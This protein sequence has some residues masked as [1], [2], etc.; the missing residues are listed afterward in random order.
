M[1]MRKDPT[2][3][4]SIRILLM[5]TMLGG[6]AWCAVPAHAGFGDMVK[7]AKQAVKGE[8]PKAPNAAE[9]GPIKSRMTPE[10]TAERLTQFQ[11]GMEAEVAEREKGRKFLAT[12]KSKE[13]YNACQQKVAASPEAQKVMMMVGDV[14]ENATM[15]DM[16][17]VTEKMNTQIAA[18]LRK[19]CGEDPSKYS[20][21]QFVRSAI[22]KGS[23]TAALGD[24]LA[25]HAW[26]EWVVEFCRYIE[27]LKDQPDYEQKLA[28]IKDEGLR[29]P[30]QG[31]GIYFVYSATEANL[32]LERCEHL[33][34]LIEATW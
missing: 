2:M 4:L 16:Q 6:L 13:E 10:V 9:T 5:L 14:P 15:E 25:Y 8:K 22:A 30:G 19:H 17:K 31:T 23:D 27:K 29:I 11:H 34:P 1:T 24:D 32:L 7:K 18:L 21:D 3:R 33:M 28:K 20:A 26:K 12:L